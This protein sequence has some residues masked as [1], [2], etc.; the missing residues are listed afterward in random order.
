MSLAFTCLIDG[1]YDLGE[2][3][4]WDADT[5]TLY[6]ANIKGRTIHAYDWGSRTLRASWTFAR[7]VG[8]FGLC[9]DGRLIVAVWDEVVLFDMATGTSEVIARIEADLPHTRLNDGK[10]GPDGAFWVG[11]MDLR[12]PREPVASLY[13]VAHDGSVRHVTGDLRVSNGLAWSPDGKTLY[14]ADSGPGWIDSWDFDVATGEAS[15][16]RRFAQLTN[17]T[18]RPDGG[19]VD[20]AGNYWSAG[21]SAGILNCF[22]PDGSLT[23]A[24]PMPV[25]RPTMPCFCGP[26]LEDLVVTSLRPDDAAALEAYPRSGSLFHTRPGVRGLPADRFGPLD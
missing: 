16:R 12:S 24:H 4:T 20:A 10:V 22:A 26:D 19:T 1:R 11:T 23:G 2:C 21:V 5:G 15:N 6:F 8:S 7:D 25:P 17:E 13:R 18:G 3:P 14:H 9:R